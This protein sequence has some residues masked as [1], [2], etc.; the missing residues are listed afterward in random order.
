[1]G[2]LRICSSVSVEA[3]N[4]TYSGKAITATPRIS[5]TWENTVR[6]GRFST[7]GP[8]SVLH[9]ALDEAELQRRQD[10]DD[11]H[12]DD[13]LR[14]RAAEIGGLHAVVIH[15]VDED[16]RV[17]RRAAP[18][19]SMAAASMSERGMDCRPARKKRK[20]YEICF[21]TEAITTS[22][23]AWSPRRIQFQS[24]PQRRSR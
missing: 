18:A 24:T 20:L 3:T 2:T 17:L 11:A 23:I 5:T 8:P 4:V 6:P 12:Q 7:M 15:L 9:L 21:Q 1:M 14:G 13:R 10:D 19:P 16:L 22:S